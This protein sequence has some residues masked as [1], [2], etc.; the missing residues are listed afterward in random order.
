MQTTTTIVPVQGPP[1]PDRYVFSGKALHPFVQL[2]A[3]API[4]RCSHCWGTRE[5]HASIARATSPVRY[6]RYAEGQLAASAG[7]SPADVDRLPKFDK[8]ALRD[9]LVERAKGAIP[10]E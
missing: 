8:L 4:G 9:R 10:T 5:Q 2:S 6:N 1:T 7:L 3:D